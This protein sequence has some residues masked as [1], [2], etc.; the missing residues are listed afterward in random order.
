MLRMLM[1]VL[2][3]YSIFALTLQ[4][5]TL[6]SEQFLNTFNHYDTI[7]K[8]TTNKIIII[9]SLRIRIIETH[10]QTYELSF[11]G[12]MDSNLIGC[13]QFF[14]SGNYGGTLI[15]P[16]SI[17]KGTEFII[18]N[19]CFDMCCVCPTA[20]SAFNTGLNKPLISMLYIYSKD[21]NDSM[22]I[23]SKQRI[24]MVEV[25]NGIKTSIVK[26]QCGK[27]SKFNLIGQ[28]AGKRGSLGI[29]IESKKTI[30]TK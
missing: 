28:K 22:V 26:Q 2:I 3:P 10:T 11:C 13:C 23:V 8:N 25:K 18:T 5:D 17:N 1:V 7:L 15:N 27:T 24:T 20:K 9:D 30:K 21:G 4:K 16:F 29:I 12:L 6:Y 19:I 14:S